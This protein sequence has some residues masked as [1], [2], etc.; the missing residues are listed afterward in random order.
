[1]DPEGWDCHT[2]FYAIQG[3]EPRICLKHLLTESQLKPPFDHF[4]TS[5]LPEGNDGIEL[6]IFIVFHSIPSPEASSFC[7]RNMI[8][9]LW[10]WVMSLFHQDFFFNFGFF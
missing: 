10:G 4:S 3:I 7:L 1:M 5:L 6:C 9:E 8:G 2:Q